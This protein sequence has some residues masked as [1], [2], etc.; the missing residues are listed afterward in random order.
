MAGPIPL[1]TASHPG[2]TPNAQD[3]SMPHTF[4][5]CQRSRTDGGRELVVRE[6]RGEGSYAR[7]YRGELVGRG[8]AVECAV[9]LA[10]AEVRGAVEM[11]ARER[12]VLRERCYENVVALLDTGSAGAPFL[13]LTW[14]EGMP[15][16]GVMERQRQLPLVNALA[17]LRD[18]A[19]AVSSL[20]RHGV[21]HGDLRADNVIV[22]PSE[23]GARITDL[24]S[25]VR[26]GQAG[27]EES[28]RSD[29]R[30]LGG[31]LHWMLT[32]APVDGAPPRLTRAAGFH[33]DAVALYEATL[34]DP[35]PDARTLVT[36]AESLL[37][38]LQLPS[39]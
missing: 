37:K 3:S 14:F 30:R 8:P 20:H 39:R 5:L 21:A 27:F 19:V 18:L 13:A 34:A 23:R 33:R 22:P 35:L 24:G 7:V 4:Q 9:K 12:D 38:H 17:A 16:R 29:I 28:C 15:L 10:K 36:H 31:L 1:L 25:A 6:W 2:A 26:R 32:G 11:L